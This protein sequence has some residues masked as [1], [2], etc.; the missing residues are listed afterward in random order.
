MS[1]DGSDAIETAPCLACGRDTPV[2]HA[3]SS[4]AC[5]RPL[6]AECA[7]NDDR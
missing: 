6:C 4:P 1:E 2:V 5:Y 7:A 3:T